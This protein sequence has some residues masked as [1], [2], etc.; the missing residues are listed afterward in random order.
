MGED[1]RP[2][3][4][5]PASREVAMQTPRRRRQEGLIREALYVFLAIAVVMAVLLDG[6]A[7]F[8]VQKGARENASDAGSE[9]RQAYIETS[10]VDAAREAAARQAES[11]DA[12]L[13][14]FSVA[15][16]SGTE[17]FTV[18]VQHHTDTYLFKYLK[19][20][21]GLDDW[22]DEVQNPTITRTTE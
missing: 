22:V 15:T 6:V 18:T 20:L 8:T 11:K 2:D 17:T 1:V 19:Y 14:A 21:P 3:T 4:N 9:A 16:V 13:V 5:Q 7:I 10:S 12:D